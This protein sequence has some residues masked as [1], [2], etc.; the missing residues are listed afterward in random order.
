M[1]TVRSSGTFLCLASAAA[2]GAMGIFGKLAYDEHVTVGTLLAVRFA[3][4]ATLFW[5]LLAARGSV[6]EVRKLRR[7]DLLAALA[8]GACGYAAQAGTYFAALERID[9]SLLAL[10]LY[11]FPVI[12]AVAAV[13]LGRER[14]GWRKVAAL[15]MA[16]FG[17]VLVLSSA[18]AGKLDPVGTA[19]GLSAACIYS[20]YILVGEGV[21]KRVPAQILS[22]LVCTGAAVTLTIGSA[23][24]GQ[25]HPG[26]VT[27]AGWGWLAAI[28]LVST[29]AA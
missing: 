25:L 14:L 5:A 4:A 2:F 7:R 13:A 20:A 28:A 1:P 21:A 26:D 12:V 15:A 18:Q 9:A 11:T 29:V 3:L 23:L 10:V 24:L 16:S 6:G 27:A 17:L 22:T 19:L 8:L